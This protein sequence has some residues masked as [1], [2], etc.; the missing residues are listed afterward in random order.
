MR[1]RG[2]GALVPDGPHGIT[3]AYAGK[4]RRVPAKL[5]ASRDHPRV[6][7]EECAV[8]GKETPCRGSPPRMRGRGRRHLGPQLL[9]GITPAYA[10]K[11]VSRGHAPPAGR[12]HPRVCGEE[13]PV[14][15]GACSGLGSPPRM[16]GRASGHTLS[17][18]LGRI[19][20]AYAGKSSARAVDE[21][22]S[23]DH[24]RVCGEEYV[25]DMLF[26]QALGSPPRMRGRD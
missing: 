19:T 11:S 15:R 20:P 25:W 24:P 6:C 17:F 7:G 1:G 26:G 12:D 18:V 16:R 22:P 14:R 2:T 13:R 4:R 5:A 9:H 3:P 8:D 23:G 21:K 10:G